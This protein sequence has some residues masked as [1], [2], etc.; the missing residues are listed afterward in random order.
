M[1]TVTAMDGQRSDQELMTA[2]G[3]GDAGAFG[4]LYARHKAP[5]YRYFKRQC[6]VT[7]LADEL[8]QETWARVIKARERYEATAKFTTWLYR[9]AHNLLMDYGRKNTRTPHLV[10]VN[11]DDEP[12]SL[13][14]SQPSQDQ[15]AD[16]ASLQQRLL[17][18]IEQLPEEQ[19]SA[20]LLKEE[21]ALS[22]VEIGE[23]LGVGRETVKSRLRYATQKL[24]SALADEQQAF[25]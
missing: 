7:E 1:L 8:F 14:A 20:F 18:A 23:I 4:E 9:I 22:L 15:L 17:Q 12:V 10:T 11:H 6:P 3:T 2:Y 24:R 19:R 25:L 21:G 16:A 13:V 5:L